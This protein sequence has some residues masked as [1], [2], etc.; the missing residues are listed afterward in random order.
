MIESVYIT[1]GQQRPGAFFRDEWSCFGRGLIVRV[2]CRTRTAYPVTD[3]I[4][5]TENRPEDNAS[6][7]FKAGAIRGDELFVCTQT[8]VLIYSVTDFSLTNCISLPCFNDVHHVCPTDRDTL[9]V[10]VTG[11]DMVVELERNGDIV[12]EWGVLGKAPWD[13][14]DDSL[15][16]R[17]VLTTKPHAS[18]PNYTF[19]LDGEVW[20]T[21]LKQK[22]SVCLTS[23]DKRLAIDVGRPHDGNVKDGR[24][25]FTTV[26]GQIV[27]FDA[28]SCERIRTGRP[29]RVL[30]ER[31]GAR[32]VPRPARDQRRSRLSWLL[33]ASPEQSA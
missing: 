25:Y 11:L 17:K 8:E 3:Y 19:E 32:L 14:Y 29:Q 22:D 21:R 27:V 18:H 6:V 30:A 20:A 31:Q 12:R 28:A 13:V 26:D 16:Y 2:D 5:P 10:A 24:V 4:S 23:S 7:L 15:D 9:L 1:G 33:A